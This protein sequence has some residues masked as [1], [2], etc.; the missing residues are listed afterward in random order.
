MDYVEVG[1]KIVDWTVLA[2]GSDQLQ[3]VMHT[4]MN[5]GFIKCE[6]LLV[7]SS[8]QLVAQGHVMAFFISSSF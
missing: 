4:V 8:S 3:T 7:M 2:D 6:H 5:F 1:L